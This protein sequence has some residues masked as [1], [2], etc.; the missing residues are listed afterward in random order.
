MERDL[1]TR[2]D[3]TAYLPSESSGALL[4]VRDG[5]AIPD[6]ISINDNGVRH[7]F[8]IYKPSRVKPNPHPDQARG[9]QLDVALATVM[10]ALTQ[11]D[12]RQVHYTMAWMSSVLTNKGRKNPTVWAMLGGGG[13]GK[14]TIGG[15]LMP[16]LVG[17]HNTGL[18]DATMLAKQFSIGPFVDRVY[19]YGDELE[20]KGDM[21]KANFKRIIKSD[22]IGGEL[23]YVGARNYEIHCSVA[24]SMN[25]AKF[26]LR[27]SGTSDMSGERSLYTTIGWDEEGRKL[28][29]NEFTEWRTK[30]VQPATDIIRAVVLNGDKEG[31]E[32]YC[33][34]IAA[35]EY[36]PRLLEDNSSAAHLKTTHAVKMLNAPV[37]VL[38]RLIKNNSFGNDVVWG[39]AIRDEDLKEALKDFGRMDANFD[40][41]VSAIVSVMKRIGAIADRSGAYVPTMKRGTLIKALGKAY[42]IDI[43]TE[44][45]VAEDEFGETDPDS[46]KVLPRRSARFRF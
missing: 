2:I 4:Y 37:R 43:E 29:M 41:S 36:E 38:I 34:R 28:S 40:V 11:D 30:H 42:N 15:M 12:A 1:L 35:Y 32:H 10:N 8:N 16:A 25:N 44:C 17:K 24:V 9:K 23:K 13:I 22:D 6:D 46:V 39:Q 45:S 18:F 14:T 19:A 7:V 27:T 20:L 3:D 5:K 31:L 21:Q 33:Y 26:D